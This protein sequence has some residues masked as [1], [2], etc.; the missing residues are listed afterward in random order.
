MTSDKDFIIKIGDLIVEMNPSGD[1]TYGIITNIDKYL[2]I[3]IFWFDIRD[4]F[5][6]NIEDIKSFAIDSNPR[7]WEIIRSK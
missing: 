5:Y 4:F 3:E 1:I 7:K 6:Y 2:D